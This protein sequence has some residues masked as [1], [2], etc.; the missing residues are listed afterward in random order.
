MVWG[1][2]VKALIFLRA[3]AHDRLFEGRGVVWKCKGGSLISISLAP[4]ASDLN[5]R[6][7]FNILRHDCCFY[8][9]V[10]HS[11]HLSSSGE[12]TM[13]CALVYLIVQSLATLVCSSQ[14]SGTMYMYIAPQFIHFNLILIF[15]GLSQTHNAI[16]TFHIPILDS[17]PS[18]DTV[19]RL[20]AVLSAEPSANSAKSLNGIPKSHHNGLDDDQVSH[21]DS[22]NVLLP[23]DGH[24]QTP[25][26][27]PFQTIHRRGARPVHRARPVHNKDN[28]HHSNLNKDIG[29]PKGSNPPVDS[30]RN[31]DIGR[32][33]GSN[34][35]VDSNRNKD[36]GRPK[37]SNPPVDSNRNKDIGRPKGSN[38]PVDSN[39]NKDIGRPKGSNPPVDSNR[40]KD[41]G[42]PKGSNPPVDSNRNKDIGR[43]K[44]SNP[45]VDSN[46]YKD[47]GRPKGSNPPVDSNR[48]KDIG[49]PKGS[50]PPVDSNRNK[51]IGRHEGSERNKGIGQP[52]GSNHHVD[53]ERN[54][55]ILHP[56]RPDLSHHN[57]GKH[58]GKELSLSAL[59]PH[60]HKVTHDKRPSHHKFHHHSHQP[61]VHHRP[62]AHNSHLHKQKPAAE[63][64]NSASVTVR[65]FQL[66]S[67]VMNFLLPQKQEPLANVDN[68]HRT[69]A[70]EA[71][72]K[73]SK[74]HKD[75][76]KPS[77]ASE[78]HR[79]KPVI[80]KNVKKPHK[81]H[82]RAPCLTCS[83]PSAPK[84]RSL[85]NTISAA[86]GI[87]GVVDQISGIPN[88]ISGA[89]SS[90]YNSALGS[91]D[92]ASTSLESYSNSGAGAIQL[93]TISLLSLLCIAV[94]AVFL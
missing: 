84:P 21:N 4:D 33:K 24:Q 3:P 10:S 28:Q 71:L 66:P 44:G 63:N 32:P 39:R 94:L 54:K 78:N 72:S 86:S 93:P 53:L 22:Q 16:A 62:A 8:G 11:V 82:P 36:I 20:S 2:C 46:H 90:T 13:L 68:K 56:K 75:H 65:L 87:G 31:K 80:G 9:N 89:A 51:D 57:K 43:P 55:D 41:I 59:H 47:I 58:L 1:C 73:S 48:N 6:L 19:T 69:H 92:S 74:V 83:N 91:L 81:H 50:N 5:L 29:R 64:I 37:G 15:V 18:P 60:H 25:D 12:T 85:F 70:G 40:N 49:R 23:D 77:L 27:A 52:K 67:V 38:P 26:K 17:Q 34:P 35:P 45:P 14:M 88:K 76:S 42:R 61:S 79:H 30:N 7:I